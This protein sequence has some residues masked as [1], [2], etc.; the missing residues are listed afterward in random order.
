MH[1]IRSVAELAGKS[2]DLGDDQFGHTSRVGK[3]RVENS[4]SMMRCELNVHLV[5]ANAETTNDEQVL[6]FS[7]N[8]CRQLGLRSNAN[9]VHI[10]RNGVSNK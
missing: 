8:L 4:Y 10:S 2:D 9:D 7:E 6:R 1:L 5:G 3:R